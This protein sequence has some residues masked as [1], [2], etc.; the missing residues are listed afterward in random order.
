MGS[1]EDVLADLQDKKNKAKEELEKVNGGSAY[2]DLDLPDDVQSALFDKNEL[3]KRKNCIEVIDKIEEALVTAREKL[4]DS[5]S[6]KIEDVKQDIENKKKKI[7]ETKSKKEDYEKELKDLNDKE[8]RGED[9]TEDEKDRKDELEANILLAD[10]KIND[11]TKELSDFEKDLK[12]QSDKLEQHKKEYKEQTGKDYDPNSKKNE[13]EKP[14]QGDN[15]SKGGKGG[16]GGGVGAVQPDEKKEEE[17]DA[18]KREQDSY[19]TDT[20]V[21][22]LFLDNVPKVK[23]WNRPFVGKKVNTKTANL[24]K[25][26]KPEEKELLMN[27]FQNPVSLVYYKVPDMYS[28]AIMNAIKGEIDGLDKSK[29]KDQIAKLEQMYTSVS[30]ACDEKNA[31]LYG[32][33]FKG[34]SNDKEVKLLAAKKH[35]IR[36]AAEAGKKDEVKTLAKEL[37]GLVESSTDVARE[38]YS[39]ADKYKES[40][41]SKGL[42]NTK[43]AHDKKSF[44]GREK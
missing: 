28:K 7:E 9:L 2:A 11:K 19:G 17:K 1:W 14:D 23:W 26:L 34:V 6:Q 36:V 38:D 37:S 21:Y 8:A 43:V 31:R 22:S 15:K 16:V 4:M 33:R 24:M 32:D 35:D 18:I 12:D 13:P 42:G 29:D 41:K 40:V 30:V 27:M 5:L 39:K 44:E 20:E 25:Q 10:K 3:E